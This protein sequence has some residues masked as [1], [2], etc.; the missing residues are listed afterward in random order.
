MTDQP[1]HLGLMK[2]AK[3]LA[4]RYYLR[5]SGTTESFRLYIGPTKDVNLRAC[6]D[7]RNLM[8]LL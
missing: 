1:Q 7:L 6:I 3:R 8:L 5:E 4:K 2:Q